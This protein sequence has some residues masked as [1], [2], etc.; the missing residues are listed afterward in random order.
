MNQYISASNRT[1]HSPSYSGNTTTP[2][3]LCPA[4]FSWW[5]CSCSCNLSCQCSHNVSDDFNKRNNKG[6]VFF[7]NTIFLD[8]VWHIFTGCLIISSIGVVRCIG[9]G[10]SRCNV[11]SWR[12]VISKCVIGSW[13]IVVP[14]CSWCSWCRGRW[15]SSCWSDLT[16]NLD[17]NELIIYS[18][19]FILWNYILTFSMKKVT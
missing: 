5:T 15:W 14:V 10:V 16:I 6:T 3:S 13:C 1:D 17:K 18:S 9:V 12:I 2:S 11:V 8:I 4:W 7:W 19:L